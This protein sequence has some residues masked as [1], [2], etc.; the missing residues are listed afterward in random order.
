MPHISA[1]IDEHRI[2]PYPPRQWWEKVILAA[3]VIGLAA[4]G[5]LAVFL[6]AAT[7]R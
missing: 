5:M 6:H 1:P 4:A 3:I 7:M 2:I